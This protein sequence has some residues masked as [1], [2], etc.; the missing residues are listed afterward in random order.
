M[1]AQNGHNENFAYLELPLLDAFLALFEKFG[2]FLKGV[3]SMDLHGALGTDG[4][5]IALVAEPKRIGR[6]AIG[7]DC[8]AEAS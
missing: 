2:Q 6:V 8:A 7:A 3:S 4:H 1:P 5:L